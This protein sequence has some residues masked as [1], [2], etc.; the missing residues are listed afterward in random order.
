MLSQKTALLLFLSLIL[1]GLTVAEATACTCAGPRSGRNF[2]PCGVFWNSD[3]VFIGTAENVSIEKDGRMIVRFAVEKA[4]RGVEG[5]TV[6][7]ETAASTATCGYPFKQGETYFAYLRRGKDGK[8]SE[9]LCGA[10]VLLKDAATDLEYLKAVENGDTGGKIYGSV[11]QT[12]RKFYNDR[13]EYLPV[14]GTKITLKSIKVKYGDNRNAPK[15]KKIE[16]QT[17]TDDKGFYLF[18]DIPAGLYKVKAEFQ[19]NLRELYTSGDMSGHYVSINEDKIRCNGY[20]FNATS[21]GSLEGVVVMSDGQTP[22]QQYISL[23]P[24]D[25]NGKP[26]SEHSSLFTWINGESGQFLFNVV[27]PG[28]YLLAVNPKNCPRREHSEFGKSFFPGVGSEP[29]AEI[30]SI[31]ENE[32]KKISNF[33]LLPTLKERIFMGV[34]LNAEKAPLKNAKVFLLARNDI[35]AGYS[36]LAETITDEF[37]R[38]QI[39]GYEGYEYKIRAYVEKPTRLYSDLIDISAAGNFEHL[40]LIVSKTY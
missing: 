31:A 15:Y 11:F 18:R 26:Y 40:E 16:V 21:Q 38:F 17:R 19:N 35:C 39:K 22:P 2:Q 9:H 30:I 24:L 4:I 10:T 7:V 37:G 6:E 1:F 23:I 25:E 13:G 34:A 33:R 12:I 14:S 5:A 28:K 27:P 8:L 29:E 32:R 3:V 20:N 36:N